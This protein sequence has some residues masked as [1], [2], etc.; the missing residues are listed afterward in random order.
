[1]VCSC[2][3]SYDASILYCCGHL[4]FH[5]TGRIM[6]PQSCG[7]DPCH[8]ISRFVLSSSCGNRSCHNT[9]K[10][11]QRRLCDKPLYD[12]ILG[13]P[14]FHANRVRSASE[15]ALAQRAQNPVF[16]HL[17]QRT[18]PYHADMVEMI[19]L[20]QRSRRD[21]CRSPI[22][23]SELSKSSDRLGWHAHCKLFRWPNG[24]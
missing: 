9:V 12:R 2:H 11:M 7:S 20:W 23:V 21:E 8:T 24:R 18:S 19:A 16:R 14:P 15:R 6:F 10:S 22:D 1:M 3:D 17:W 4:L 5:N 13:I